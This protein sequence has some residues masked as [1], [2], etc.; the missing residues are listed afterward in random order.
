MKLRNLFFYV[1]V[2]AISLSASYAAE[3]TKA[4]KAELTPPSPI[5]T[6]PPKSPDDDYLL[7]EGDRLKIRI[8]PEDEFIKG[9]E[10]PVSS[11]GSI[12]IP[13]VGKLSVTGKTVLQAERELAVILSRD[14]LV[15]PEVVIEVQK[16]KKVTFV[17]LGQVKVPGTYD[18]PEGSTKLT[19]LQ[20]ISMAGGFSE[21][22]NIK[23]IKVVRKGPGKNQVIRANAE[24]IISGKEEDVGLE[25]D[26]IIHVMESLF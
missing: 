18:M 17:I 11:E 1:L 15:N 16:Y 8:F 4:E 23:K 19:L 7:Q 26:D 20:A 2:S 6:Q 24:A 21:I 12:T 25:P 3:E 13:L 10:M 14:F 22:A 9:G 5:D